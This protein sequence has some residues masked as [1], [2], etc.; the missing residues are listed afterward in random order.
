[1]LTLI[2]QLQQQTT[3]EAMAMS[4]D[5]NIRYI[6]TYLKKLFPFQ[7]VY[8]NTPIVSQNIQEDVYCRAGLPTWTMYCV[9]SYKPKELMHLSHDN[10]WPISPTG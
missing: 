7:N 9:T 8:E 10:L 6:R 2:Q 5:L 1:M 4:R 3:D